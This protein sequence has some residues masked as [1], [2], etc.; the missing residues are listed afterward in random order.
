MPETLEEVEEAI[1]ADESAASRTYNKLLAMFQLF[2]VGVGSS[3]DCT[4]C[5]PPNQPQLTSC[6]SALISP[7]AMS[8][9]QL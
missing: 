6:S 7:V 1:K 5:F 2:L 9:D 4:D 3:A 8:L